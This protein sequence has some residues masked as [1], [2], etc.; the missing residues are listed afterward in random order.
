MNAIINARILTN[1]ELVE[2]KTIL[3]D[4]K[5]ISIQEDIPESCQRIDAK[6][7]F[8]SAG[9]IDMHIHG[10]VGVEFSSNITADDIQRVSSE[11]LKA[12]LPDICRH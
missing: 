9:F 6:G 7:L 5:I 4:E 11:L 3:Y 12:E 10:F 1:G 8:V 2:G